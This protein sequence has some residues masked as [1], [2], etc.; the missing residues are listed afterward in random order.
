MDPAPQPDHA[1]TPMSE[2]DTE[3][4][5][6]LSDVDRKPP[7][8][9][10]PFAV[11]LGNASLLGIGYVV[12]R[13][14]WLAVL[15]FVV[16]AVLVVVL[17]EST[18][19]V[20]L[21]VVVV[22]WW[23][24]LV[25]HGWFL[26]RRR[27][28]PVRPWAQRA[29]ALAV[30]V[31]VLA[32]FGLLRFDA[33]G[34]EQDVTEARGAG[35]CRQATTA[36]DRLWLGHRVVDA[37]LVARAEE[38]VAACDRLRAADKAL[39]IALT[40]NNVQLEAG[41][42]MLAEVRAE[43]PGHEKMVDAALARFLDRLSA[44]DPCD[45][46]TTTDWLGRHKPRGALAPAAEI[47]PR[48]APQAIA[49]CADRFMA[50]HDWSPARILYQQLLDEYPD[51]ELAPTAR[52]NVRKA[53][54]EIELATVRPK[55]GPNA[56]AQPAYCTSP[57]PYSGAAPYRPGRPNRALLYGSPPN[58]GKIPAGW[59]ASDVTNAVV[60]ICAGE[61]E[62]GGAVDTCLYDST[63]DPGVSGWVTFRKIA[64][65]LRVFEVRTGRLVASFTVE[66]GGASCPTFLSWYGSVTPPSSEYVAASPADV[67]AAFRPL[68]IP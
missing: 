64:I 16:T 13:R 61:S 42:A 7:R 30:T 8:P 63:T 34:I 57:S 11:A 2:P 62:Y 15:T 17:V 46:R 6:V 54:L 18:P 4:L 49:G 32:A 56:T 22:L 23:A 43:R 1:W 58:T 25:V 48:I 67:Q 59:L 40:G 37:P 68:L 31:P 29:I 45:V 19:A 9:A 28:R 20:W 50:A 53:T 33:A 10:D 12:L 3:T 55:L 51:H 38:T 39:D 47:V 27:P 41:L 36:T 5:P 21:E 24:A 65:P 26:A 35:D 60:V 66:I 14:T 44:G 52:Q